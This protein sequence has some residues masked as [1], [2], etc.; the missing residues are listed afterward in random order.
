MNYRLELLTAIAILGACTD[1]GA[2]SSAEPPE[3]ASQASATKDDPAAPTPVEAKA[4]PQGDAS[5][6]EAETPRPAPP[7][8]LFVAAEGRCR[9]MATS[10]VQGK[11]FV[12]YSGASIVQLE[13]DGTVSGGSLDTKTP[14]KPGDPPWDEYLPQIDRL[15]GTK[16]HLWAEVFESPREGIRGVYRQT[17]GAWEP[18]RLFGKDIP[19]DHMYSWY[20]G[21]QL[22]FTD[23]EGGGNAKFGVYRGK[24][25]GPRFDSAKT[26]A[27]CSEVDVDQILV[28]ERGDVV[29]TWT[30]RDKNLFVTHW[31]KGDLEGKT[32]N[33]GVA[34]ETFYND[35]HEPRS[36]AADDTDGYYVLAGIKTDEQKLWHGKDAAWKQLDL[37][38]GAGVWKLA[39]D[40]A[41]RLWIAGEKLARRDGDAW[42][43]IALPDGKE[44]AELAGVEFG[45][46]WIRT[47]MSP[48]DYRPGGRLWRI[49][50]DKAVE[51][52]VPSSAFFEDEALKVMR[53]HFAG[54]DDVW[55]DTEFVVK[56]HGKGGPGRYYH[57]VLHSVPTKHPLRCGELI[58]GGDMNQAFVPWPT[59]AGGECK[60]RL[61]LLMRRKG[62]D[63]TN[64]YAKVQKAVKSIE[65]IADVRF[66]ELE[67]G[68]EKFFAAITD[69][70]TKVAT[71]QKK[72]KKLRPY[73]YPEV[74][75]GDEAVLT[76]AG[77]VVHREL[78]FAPQ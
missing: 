7:T 38:K 67:I 71:I 42:T 66:V 65:G 59:A 18:V 30:C 63:D 74:V 69:D 33:L 40:P 44:I 21:S 39:T 28:L 37:P 60:Q 24:P 48:T 23:Q 62:W 17:A 8:Q 75:C 64:T 54:P 32:H 36:I 47:G 46:P 51:V 52:T 49:A 72:I 53:M 70:A 78:S 29:V 6:D 12:H 56:R 25:K 26:K 13:P 58:D 68:K 16:N 5:P 3:P 61:A 76:K 9:Y 22:A 15:H 73:T 50:D 35:R 31:R 45:T 14:R 1:H 10:I 57:S 4:E 11:A 55:V 41:G 77:V 27:G 2:E 34:G 19:V 43:E 20:D